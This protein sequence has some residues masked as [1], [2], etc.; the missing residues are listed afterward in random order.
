M[1]K[2][3]NKTTHKPTKNRKRTTSKT[4][5][6]VKKNQASATKSKKAPALEQVNN[7]PVTNEQ[8]E[9]ETEPAAMSEQ[10][11]NE[12]EQPTTKSESTQSK[13]PTAE[14]SNSKQEEPVKHFKKSHKYF[15]R[16]VKTMAFLSIA[17][18]IAML[19]NVIRFNILP[20]KYLVIIIVGIVLLSAL[21]LFLA[22]FK[23]KQ[24][25]TR[26]LSC[27]NR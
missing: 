17:G 24:K 15:G 10:L 26:A 22:F 14:S 18:F 5:D 16:F 25:P 8:D 13:Q 12:L 27:T 23:K 20:T 21:N 1:K 19:V 2:T 6:V 7:Q 11:I 9:F 4:T 3:T